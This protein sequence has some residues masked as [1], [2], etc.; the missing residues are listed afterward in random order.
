MSRHLLTVAV[1]ASLVVALAVGA[2]LIG[3]RIYDR[4]ATT[5]CISLVL[6]LGL[7][8]FMGNSASSP[9]PISASWGSA[10][11]PPRC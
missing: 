11:T 8:V 10:P 1:L 2:E 4:I 3:I 5:L 7:Q 6:V 9:S